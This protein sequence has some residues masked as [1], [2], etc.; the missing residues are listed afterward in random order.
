MAIGILQTIFI[1]LFLGGSMY[2]LILWS[3]FTPKIQKSRELDTLELRK[4]TRRIMWL[5]LFSGLSGG[6]ALAIDPLYEPG[7]FNK[8]I[9]IVFCGVGSGLFVTGSFLLKVIL[10]RARNDSQ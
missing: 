10:R 1:M 8:F 6:A 3:K 2:W 5:A 9:I 7:L 4:V